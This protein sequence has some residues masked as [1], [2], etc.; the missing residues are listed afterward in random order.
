MYLLSRTST[1]EGKTSAQK[2]QSHEEIII[3]IHLVPNN[4]K[5]TILPRVIVRDGPNFPATSIE[6]KK[7]SVLQQSDAVHAWS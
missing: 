3:I 7:N 5:L 2:I 1:Y 4:Y 6:R